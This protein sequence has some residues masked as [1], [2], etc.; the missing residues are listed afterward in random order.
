MMRVP[1]VDAVDG[2]LC[3]DRPRRDAVHLDL[4]ECCKQIGD[5]AIGLF[6]APAGAPVP[7]DLVKPSQLTPRSWGLA[8]K[9]S[10]VRLPPE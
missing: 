9:P 3:R 2:E 7:V 4:V 6:N 8:R 1:E 10:Q 5:V